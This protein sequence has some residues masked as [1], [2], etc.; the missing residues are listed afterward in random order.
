M[1]YKCKFGSEEFNILLMEEPQIFDEITCDKGN[2]I[3]MGIEGNYLDQT[4]ILETI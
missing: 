2:F 3:V 4:L 1:I